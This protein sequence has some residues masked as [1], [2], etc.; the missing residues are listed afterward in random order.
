LFKNKIDALHNNKPSI[1]HC[2]IVDDGN[3]FPVGP[4]GKR[5]G[6]STKTNAPKAGNNEQ[7]VE[8]DKSIEKELVE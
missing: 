5:I 7:N 6:K 8:R 1:S 4:V 2:I 3:F